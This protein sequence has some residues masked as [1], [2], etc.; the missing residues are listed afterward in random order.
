MGTGSS[1]TFA[2]RLGR[3]G[4]SILPGI[5]MV[6]Y[7]VGTGS[8]TTMAAAGASYG[9]TLVWTLALASL[10]THIM[11]AA[12]SKM[13]IVSG[14]TMLHN[15]R[16][17]FGGPVTLFIMAATVITQIAS[18]IGVMGIVTDVIREWTRGFTPGGTGLNRIVSGMAVMLLLLWLA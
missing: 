1:A 13:T 16:K 2:S 14:D 12:I 11:F 3:F 4:A 17:H 10:F 15:F 9:M 7:V 8:V 18:I 6:G 5:F